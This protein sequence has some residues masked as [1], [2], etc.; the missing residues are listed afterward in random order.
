MYDIKVIRKGKKQ[1]ILA[2]YINILDI[3]SKN[4]GGNYLNLC[5]KFSFIPII[6]E[7][8]RIF[9]NSN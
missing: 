9:E 7:G 6:Q 4:L 8:G 5:P 3:F 2:N 1:N